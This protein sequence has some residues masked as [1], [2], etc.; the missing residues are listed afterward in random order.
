MLTIVII[1]LIVTAAVAVLVF[2]RGRIRDRGGRGLER[3][4]GPEYD[5]AI[6]DLFQ[7]HRIDP[8][9]PLEDQIRRLVRACPITDLEVDAAAVSG[10]TLCRRAMPSM[11]RHRR[12]GVG[13]AAVGGAG[14][15][16]DGGLRAKFIEATRDSAMPPSRNAHRS[17]LIR[18]TG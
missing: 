17:G 15:L 14:R 9:T 3:R 16:P 8:D 1:A 7:L 11:G 13:T 4:I 18:R 10:A 2:G 5:R 6:A 12:T